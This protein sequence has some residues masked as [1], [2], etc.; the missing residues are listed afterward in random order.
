[1]ARI[2]FK[3]EDSA[4]AE[5]VAA[6]RA[7]RGGRLLNIDR[8]LLHSQPFVSGW[9]GFLRAVRNEVAL[10]YRLREL[11]MCAVSAQINC[12]YELHHHHAEWLKAG[13]SEQQ[14][15]AL[16][17]LH[18]AINNSALFDTAERAVLRLAVEMTRDSSASAA[19]VAAARAVLPDEA[20][21]VELVGVIASYNMVGR[22][23]NTL[24]IELE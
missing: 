14:F 7:R 8:M 4:P 18:A 15:T 2:P 11:A 16:G 6:I 21:L 13:G 5:M 22:F 17:D 20:Q 12:R 9:N 3:Q 24:D 1:M 10:P 23:I 19:A